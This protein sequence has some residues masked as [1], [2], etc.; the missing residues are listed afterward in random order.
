VYQHSLYQG[1]IAQ[2]PDILKQGEFDIDWT[3]YRWYTLEQMEDDSNIMSKNKDVVSFIKE[4]SV[5]KYIYS[6][7]R[8][9]SQ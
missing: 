4:K 8:K 3:L 9:H 1:I 2:Y 6:Y 5:N 7:K